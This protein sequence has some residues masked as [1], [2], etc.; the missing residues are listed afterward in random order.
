MIE[1]LCRRIARGMHAANASY[2]N[3]RLAAWIRRRAGA[4]PKGDACALNSGAVHCKHCGRNWPPDETWGRRRET[5]RQ[6]EALGWEI[7]AD[8][9]RRCVQHGTDYSV[10]C[11]VCGPWWRESASPEELE[12]HRLIKDS[13]NPETPWPVVELIAWPIV[14]RLS[15]GHFETFSY[16]DS[17]H[18]HQ[19]VLCLRC[20]RDRET[21][22]PIELRRAV[23]AA[24][25]VADLVRIVDGRL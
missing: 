9:P 24:V 21:A 17:P 3:P 23:Q 16:T 12:R 10:L 5:D 19:S 11:P 6:L 8:V 7:L 13:L 2:P 14:A 18:L 25:S 1:W 15:C 20:S 22:D 4:C